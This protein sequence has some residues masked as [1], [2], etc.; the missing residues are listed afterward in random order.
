M[1]KVAHGISSDKATV[2]HPSMINNHRQ[3]AIPWDMCRF[4]K[5]PAPMSPPKAFARE[6]PA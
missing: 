6:L 1:G 4:P 3:P 5:T 2:M